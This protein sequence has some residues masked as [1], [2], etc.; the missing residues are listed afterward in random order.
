MRIC[1]VENVEP[2]ELC[3]IYSYGHW[4]E[5]VES[6]I[7]PEEILLRLSSPGRWHSMADKYKQY[8]FLRG[9]KVAVVA[10]DGGIRVTVV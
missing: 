9:D 4:W 6:E 5:Q 8:E 3:R 1:R 10:L 7:E 2:G